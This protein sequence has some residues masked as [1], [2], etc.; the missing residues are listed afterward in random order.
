MSLDNIR[1]DLF[2]SK[3][4]LEIEYFEQSKPQGIFSNIK[5]EDLDERGKILKALRDIP[6]KR[7]NT[8]EEQKEKMFEELNRN[9][10]KKQWN[11]LPDVYKVNKIGEYLVDIVEDEEERKELMKKVTKLVE[12]RKINTKKFVTYD[13]SNEKITALPFL[14]FED[15][16]SYYFKLK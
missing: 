9:G 7:V 2:V 1:S 15:D 14:E 6:R 3:I 16:G 11:K 10:Y 5:D 13:H 12:E 8:V 4:S